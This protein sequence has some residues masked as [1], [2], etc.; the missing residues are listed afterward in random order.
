[1]CNLNRLVYTLHLMRDAVSSRLQIQF[2]ATMIIVKE[3]R[4]T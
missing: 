2:M 4:A 3:L 1:M